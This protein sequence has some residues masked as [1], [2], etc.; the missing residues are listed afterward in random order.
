MKSCVGLLAFLCA[1]LLTS[2]AEANMLSNAYI[3]YYI[4]PNTLL[5]LWLIIMGLLICYMASY[6]LMAIQT[7]RGFI[8]KPLDFGNIEE[9]D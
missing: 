3:G 6:L 1:A 7:P 4:Q 9:A 2:E 5:G 8:T